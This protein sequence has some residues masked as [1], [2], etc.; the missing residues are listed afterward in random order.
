MFCSISNALGLPDEA[1]TVVAEAT[2]AALDCGTLSCPY[3]ADVIA[4]T[5]RL[6]TSGPTDDSFL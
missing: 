4:R 3:A 1:P 2:V 5:A 6:R